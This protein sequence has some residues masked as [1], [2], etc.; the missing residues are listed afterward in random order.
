MP[1]ISSRSSRALAAVS[2]FA[3]VLVDA[4]PRL[5]AAEA[6]VSVVDVAG[7]AESAPTTP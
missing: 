6:T 1:A 7:R 2:S 3:A 4:A 5:S